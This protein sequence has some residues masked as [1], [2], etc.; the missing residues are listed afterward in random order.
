ENGTVLPGTECLIR[1]ISLAALACFLTAAWSRNEIRNASV[2][3]IGR[4][5]AEHGSEGWI[6]IQDLGA[7][8]NGNPSDVASESFR[9][10]SSFR[11][12]NSTAASNACLRRSSWER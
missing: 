2:E 5:V 1:H 8:V 3:H 10:R 11:L 4:V 12:A 6:D 9:K 7:I